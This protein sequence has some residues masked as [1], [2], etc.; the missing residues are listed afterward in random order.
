MKKVLMQREINM[1]PYF[2][3][4]LIRVLF[5]LL[6]FQIS[7]YA[8]NTIQQQIMHPSKVGIHLVDGKLNKTKAIM[9]YKEDIAKAQ[10]ENDKIPKKDSSIFRIMTYNI[11]YWRNPENTKDVMQ[12]MI[13]AMQA[14][15]PDLVILQ[16]VSGSAG[17][18]KRGPVMNSCA[19][20]TLQSKLN[21]KDFAACNTI[22]NSWFGN[23]IA[24]KSLFTKKERFFFR[25]QH[26][27]TQKRCNLFM[28]LQLP[29]K[30][31]IS[32][33]GTHL[34]VKGPDTV[35]LSQIKEIT[36]Y[37]E[38]NLKNKNVFIAADFNSKRNSQ[39]IKY[40]QQQGFKDCFSY[41]GW[42]HPQYTHW[43]G[44]EIDFIFLSPDWNLPLA[45]CYV[46]YDAA[47][48]HLPVIMDIK[49]K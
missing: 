38:Q 8:Q 6:I 29:N 48:D 10:Q 7:L 30:Q 15:N 40:L 32:G 37:I 24:S 5:L 16:E 1:L 11:H 17:F 3:K 26:H 47:S 36:D 25:T 28:E 2:F 45:G 35:R 23:V 42:Q 33:Y 39:A 22:R 18:G 49:V 19:V 20:Q 31:L 43:A 12:D 9:Q 14:I 34:E 4:H 41:M 13:T 44:K 21:M 46:W 27:R